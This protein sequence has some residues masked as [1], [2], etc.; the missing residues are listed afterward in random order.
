MNDQFVCSKFFNRYE[1][2]KL[3]KKKNTFTDFLA[4]A[5]HLA[6]AKYTS[7]DRLAVYGSGLVL[8]IVLLI[9]FILSF[10]L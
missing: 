9:I 8:N 7:S 6:D 1:D 3:L 2:G 4:C 5:K 10:H